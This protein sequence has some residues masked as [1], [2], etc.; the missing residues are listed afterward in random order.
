MK[1]PDEIFAQL[2]TD[3]EYQAHM[4]LIDLCIWAQNQPKPDSQE[5]VPRT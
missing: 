1:T 2:K 4:A 5:S 3:S